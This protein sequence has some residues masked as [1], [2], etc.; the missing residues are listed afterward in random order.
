MSQI[1]GSYG[2]APALTLSLHSGEHTSDDLRKIRSIVAEHC[3]DT[4]LHLRVTGNA[5]Q[6]VHLV[7]SEKFRVKDSELLRGKL[8][9]W[10]DH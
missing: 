5:G 10:L 8:G 7:A 3:G 2:E 9:F 6:G 1:N 4:P